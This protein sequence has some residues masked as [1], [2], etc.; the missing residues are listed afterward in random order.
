M[1]ALGSDDEENQRHHG[2][3]TA[4]HTPRARPG[5]VK[6]SK[7]EAAEIRNA[8]GGIGNSAL[9][10]V[11]GRK[12]SIKGQV[13]RQHFLATCRAT[14]YCVASCD[15]LFPVLPLTRATNFHVAKS[16]RCFY[17]LQH[18]NLFRTE[19]V[20]R[21]INNRNLQRNILLRDKLRENVAGLLGLNAFYFLAVVNVYFEIKRRAVSMVTRTLFESTCIANN[22]F[23]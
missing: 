11:Y 15:C 9:A 13:I 1:E 6:T 5:K 17:F 22:Y 10:E 23:C 4:N 2:N 19:V 8:K 21:G 3:T 18:E 7:R 12:T 14:K 16:R 20:I